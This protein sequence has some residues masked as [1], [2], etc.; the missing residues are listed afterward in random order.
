MKITEMKSILLSHIDRIGHDADALKKI[1]KYIESIEA[2]NNRPSIADES[3]SEYIKADNAIIVPIVCDDMFVCHPKCNSYSLSSV[4][5][6]L[7]MSPGS[8]KPIPKTY[9][10]SV[11]Y[12][13]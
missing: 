13:Y 5:C 12:V 7:T 4:I 9:K 2:G 1:L 11:V 6:N 3:L 10:H 8:K